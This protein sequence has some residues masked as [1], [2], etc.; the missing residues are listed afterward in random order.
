MVTTAAS[1]LSAVAYRMN[2]MR[3]TVTQILKGLWNLP[4]MPGPGSLAVRPAHVPESRVVDFDFM[5]QQ[6]MDED[7]HAV[8]K[9]LQEK[10][11][12]ILWTP[13]NGG[14]WILTRGEDIDAIQRDYEHFSSAKSTIPHQISTVRGLP[15]EADP[16]QHAAYRN[17][18]NPWFTP[19]AIG[20]LEGEV[21]ALAADLL[22]DP[23]RGL[24]AR[25]HCEF[26]ADF[27][28]RLPI[29][30]FLRLVDLPPQDR[31][32][33]LEWTDNATRG[34]NNLER[35]L[36]FVKMNAYQ[37]Y[38]IRQ[39]RARPGKDLISQVV[40]AT[41]DGRP[42]SHDEIHGML[43]VILFGGLD[44]V[45]SLLSF[46]A[47]YLAEHP[48]QCRQLV[49]DPGLI[50]AAVD[51]LI[52]RH[53]VTNN[54][55]IVARDYVYK[56]VQFRKGDMIQIPSGLYGLDERKFDHPME[57]DFNRPS[58]VHAAFGAGPH[59]CPGS[60]LAR[61]EIKVFLEEW[62]KRIPEFRIKP[63][64][65]PRTSPGLVSGMDYLPLEWSTA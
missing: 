39:R 19:K 24:K 34:K 7:V 15:L 33:L 14:H 38:W 9:R 29:S 61:T 45:A 3:W 22:D 1:P 6:G 31:E 25:G 46:T 28:K 8:W 36:A 59:R 55:R 17:M 27:A 41:I 65:K 49:D 64:E 16:P 50:P 35:M 60:Y 37:D 56:G 32:K 51:E 40:H 5:R 30:I 62:L 13:R 18:I 20:D 23:I 10:G 58:L 54:G 53:G 52:R 12:D 4:G 21:R 57:V 43:M 63:G 11:P 47:R 48:V 44:T 26:V 42:I 2:E